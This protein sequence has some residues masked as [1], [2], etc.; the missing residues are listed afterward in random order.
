LSPNPLLAFYQSSIGKKIIVGVTGLIL[1]VYVLGLSTGCFHRY[2]YALS[3]L[4][5]RIGFLIGS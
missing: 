1:I 3:V 4:R 2:R 5:C